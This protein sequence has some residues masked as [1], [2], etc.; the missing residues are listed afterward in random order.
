MLPRITHF[1]YHKCLTVYF[2]R[3]LRVISA[4]RLDPLKGI[5]G[6]SPPIR[7]RHFNSLRE[8]FYA[9]H[10]GFRAASVNNWVIDFSKINGPYVASHFI[11][12]PRDLVVSGYFYHKA[13]SEV[14]TQVD[15]PDEEKWK[16]VN[17]AIPEGINGRSFSDFLNALSEED[18]L[19]ASIQ[20][21]RKHFEAMEAWD[22]GNP[23]CLELRYEDIVQNEVG[24]LEKLFQHYQLE[25]SAMKRAIQAARTF[26]VSRVKCKMHIRDPQPQQWKKYFTPRVRDAFEAAHPQLIS[27]LGYAWT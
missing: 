22:Y 1:S 14:W 10:V 12:D 8:K 7:Y 6:V 16:V 13:G 19:I 3:V 17:G 20:F 25:R 4:G 27:K 9:E 11:R 2:G 5:L 18:G 15:S 24:V 23:K 26:S 21:R